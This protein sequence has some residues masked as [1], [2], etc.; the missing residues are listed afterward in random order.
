MAV[1]EDDRVEEPRRALRS[2]DEVLS[3]CRQ[4]Y[5]GDELMAWDCRVLA[6]MPGL[7]DVWISSPNMN[8]V[9]TP[10]ASDTPVVLTYYGDGMMGQHE[11]FKWPQAYDHQEP[12]G[13]AAPADP[14][15]D[16]TMA[17]DSAALPEFE[18]TDLPWRPFDASDV[19]LDIERPDADIGT[20]SLDVVLRLRL[21]ARDVV[22]QITGVLNAKYPADQEDTTARGKLLDA[23]RKF[24]IHRMG[25]LWHAIAKLQEVPM[26]AIDVL[27]WYRE[28][29]RLMLEVRAWVIYETVIVPRLHNPEEDHRGLVLPVRGVITSRLRVVEDLYRI[30]VPVWCVRPLHT[31]TD[32]TIIYRVRPA[33]RCRERYPNS[34]FW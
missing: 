3:A 9:P 24:I 14:A 5:I 33:A 20:L 15:W 8:F 34:S 4:P 10:T 29:Q 23:R 16:E 18:E 11:L 28:A 26:A 7:D 32:H 19:H 25:S 17:T 2:R 22:R 13:F 27:A 21:A 12:H 30:G 31:L 1:H 6:P